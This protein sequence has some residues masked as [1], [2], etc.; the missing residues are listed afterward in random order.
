MNLNTIS[1]ISPNVHACA[2]DATG[3]GGTM[4]GQFIPLVFFFQVL[5]F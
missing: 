4:S 1:K 2:K 5:F 3:V